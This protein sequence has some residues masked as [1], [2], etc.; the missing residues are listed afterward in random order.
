MSVWMKRLQEHLQ[1][2]CAMYPCAPLVTLCC[3][4]R[5]TLLHRGSSVSLWM[6]AYLHANLHQT[7][8]GAAPPRAHIDTSPWRQRAQAA[9]PP[10]R[11]SAPIGRP[12]G[13]SDAREEHAAC[14]LE[15][16]TPPRRVPPRPAARGRVSWGGGATR[17]PAHRRPGCSQS[18]AALWPQR[19]PPPHVLV[20]IGQ[21]C[22]HSIPHTTTSVLND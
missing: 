18:G 10:S 9:P 11:P 4:P 1:P 20:A 14:W 7:D 19:A 15:E 6:T 21:R 5:D 3:L 2:E 12:P 13:N 22:Y 8:T 16:P 17:R